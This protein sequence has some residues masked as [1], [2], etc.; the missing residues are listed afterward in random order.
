MPSLPCVDPA[1]DAEPMALATI[2]VEGGDWNEALSASTVEPMRGSIP[3]A[4]RK[5]RKIARDDLRTC[6]VGLRQLVSGS[7][8]ERDEANG[9][10][11][12]VLRRRAAPHR[13]PPRR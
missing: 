10:P 6:W 7:P 5:W 9:E 1:A 13:P 12:G 3:D 11:P 2:R 8:F 4:R